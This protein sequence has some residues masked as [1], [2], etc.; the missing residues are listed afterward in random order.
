[1]RR[2]SSDGKS[3]KR[4]G[5]VGGGEGAREGA[6]EGILDETAEETTLVAADHVGQLPDEYLRCRVM[7]DLTVH[8][9]FGYLNR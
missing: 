2:R 9:T 1:M 8:T 6:W 3:K 4:K 5:S 7:A